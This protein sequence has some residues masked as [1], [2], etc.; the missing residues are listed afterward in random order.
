MEIK[1]VAIAKPTDDVNVIIGQ[2]HFIKTVEDIYEVLVRSLES[3]LGSPSR[4]PRGHAWFATPEP[5]RSLNRPRLMPHRQ[6][7]P[8]TY[9]SLCWETRSQ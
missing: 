9:L 6:S 2:S 3:S 1:T 8:V 5:T 4:R 7:R